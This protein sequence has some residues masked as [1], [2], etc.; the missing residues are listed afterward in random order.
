MKKLLSFA[1]LSVAMFMFGSVMAAQP[2]A[3]EIVG[4]WGI[5]PAYLSKIMGELPPDIGAEISCVFEFMPDS[6]ALTNMTIVM[7]MPVD[8]GVD[9]VVDIRCK[10]DCVWNYT[11]GMLLVEYSNVDVSLHDIRIT[12]DNPEFGVLIQMLKPQVEEVFV[13]ELRNSFKEEPLLPNVNVDI[14]GDIM[15]LTD[16][17]DSDTFVLK[18]AE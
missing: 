17:T 15:T 3:E 9:M 1:L 18:R 8:K 11:N 16:P 4:K 14:E 7:N 13:K 10:L 6:K 2:K 5:E 12:P